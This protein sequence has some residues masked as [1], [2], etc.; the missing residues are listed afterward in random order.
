MAPCQK[1]DPCRLRIRG[2]APSRPNPAICPSHW[3][4]AEGWKRQPSPPCGLPTRPLPS[5]RVKG[6]NIFFSDSPPFS[7]DPYFFG[8][9]PMPASTAKPNSS[10]PPRSGLLHPASR[11]LGVDHVKSYP[12][13]REGKSAGFRSH[14]EEKRGAR[15]GRWWNGGGGAT[16]C[17]PCMMQ[18]AC[19]CVACRPPPPLPKSL[20]ISSE[21]HIHISKRGGSMNNDSAHRGYTTSP[22]NTACTCLG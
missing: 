1:H 4:D 18:C 7:S 3:R 13:H 5:I 12:A 9:S 11:S 6:E 14:T 20:N 10:D 17:H 19:F 8:Q 16:P 15:E 2:A 21:R 22:A